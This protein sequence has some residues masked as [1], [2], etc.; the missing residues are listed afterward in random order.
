MGAACGVEQQVSVPDHMNMF[1]SIYQPRS[2]NYCHWT[3]AANHLSTIQWL[4]WEDVPEQ[5]VAHFP[6]FS[7][8][9]VHEDRLDAYHS[10]IELRLTHN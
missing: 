6:L 10:Y 3:L 9:A 4:V 5:G 1:C 7:D 2:V 8:H